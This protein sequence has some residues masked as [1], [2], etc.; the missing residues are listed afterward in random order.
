MG[1]P[2]SALRFCVCARICFLKF[3]LS[4]GITRVDT[5]LLCPCTHCKKLKRRWSVKIFFKS[6]HLVLSTTWTTNSYP[7]LPPQSFYQFNTEAVF[8]QRGD[9]QA[10]NT[11][12]LFP[13]FILT[14]SLLL[15]FF[16]SLLVSL[17]QE[18]RVPIQKETPWT[19]ALFS[20]GLDAFSPAKWN[21]I[22]TP[23]GNTCSGHGPT[24]QWIYL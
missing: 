1:V 11:S 20:K 18:K 12:D 7:A 10:L 17:S 16:L 4:C 8:A 24:Q 15:L 19:Q 3:Y 23:K 14:F 21:S 13:F 5:L 6:L 2:L 22:W 9:R